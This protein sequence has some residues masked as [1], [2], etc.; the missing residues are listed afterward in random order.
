MMEMMMTSVEMRSTDENGTVHVI[1]VDRSVKGI[2]INVT[3]TQVRSHDT[4]F[5][6]AFPDTISLP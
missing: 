2:N 3:Q 6:K 5:V 1:A 4:K